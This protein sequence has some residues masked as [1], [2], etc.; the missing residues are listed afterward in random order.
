MNIAKITKTKLLA[1]G[2]RLAI[3]ISGCD[4]N[5]SNCN[6]NINDFKSGNFLNE[7]EM[8][9]IIDKFEKGNYDG[10]VITGGEPLHLSNLPGLNYLLESLELVF[11]KHINTWIYTGYTFEELLR[12]KYVGVER[13]TFNILTMADVIIDGRYDESLKV[14]D[15]YRNS[16]NQRIINVN[17]TIK[18]LDKISDK[19]FDHK[20]KNGKLE[21]IEWEG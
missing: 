6:S 1:P 16:S 19:E 18:S 11:S 14:K 12:R 20:I 10:I 15:K 8:V 9:N 3:Y 2:K 13:H 4:L 7:L 5:C 17:E 21:V